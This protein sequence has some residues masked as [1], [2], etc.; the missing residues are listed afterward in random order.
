M[1]SRFV[2][3]KDSSESIIML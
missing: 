3:K 2:I 1:L